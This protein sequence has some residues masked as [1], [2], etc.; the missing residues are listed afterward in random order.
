MTRINENLYTNNI[1][2]EFLK[3]KGY[4]RDSILQE[5]S[6]S[7]DPTQRLFA[8]IILMN[9]SNKDYLAII[10]VK[11]IIKPGSLESAKR[12]IHRYIHALS[13]LN[14]P[15]YIFAF[16]QNNNMNIYSL[17]KDGIWNEIDDEHFPNYTSLTT[18]EEKKRELKQTIKKKRNV[19]IFLMICII[20]AVIT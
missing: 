11:R 13:H 7:T 19:D 12:Q 3:S 4:T 2:I 16:D 9:E 20:A 18:I 8:D 1:V 6:I 15:G 5:V 17:N 10:E 14:I